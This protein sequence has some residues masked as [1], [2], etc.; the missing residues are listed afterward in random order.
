[1]F[2]L[3]VLGRKSLYGSF[4]LDGHGATPNTENLETDKREK[5]L[6]TEEVSALKSNKL[7]QQNRHTRESGIQKYY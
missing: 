6:T 2:G 7:L 4:G 5:L 3:D 1:M